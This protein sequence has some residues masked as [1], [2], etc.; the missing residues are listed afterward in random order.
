MDSREASTPDDQL[1][2]GILAY[3]DAN[4]DKSKGP[5]FLHS[6]VVSHDTLTW[7]FCGQIV[8]LAK[9]IPNRNIVDQLEYCLSPNDVNIPEPPGLNVFLKGLAAIKIDNE[10]IENAQVLAMLVREGKEESDN[11]DTEEETDCKE[12]ESEQPENER[13]PR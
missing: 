1:I 6:L 7:H 13:D 4:V 10:C 8:Y 11:D 9:T 3:F 2:Q 12:E 5:D